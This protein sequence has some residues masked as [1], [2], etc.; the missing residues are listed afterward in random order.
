MRPRSGS[1]KRKL[2]DVISYANVVS[3]PAPANSVFSSEKIE[4]LT[5]NIATVTSLS[6]K[7][8]T[9]L[10]STPESD[11]KMVLMDMSKAIRLLNENQ[12]EI[13][14]AQTATGKNA[15]SGTGTGMVSLGVVPKRNRVLSQ[16]AAFEMSHAPVPRQ[17]DTIEA[18]PQFRSARKSPNSGKPSP[19]LRT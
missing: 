17:P 13:V 1:V 6:E 16:A 18:P 14:K 8:D 3:N 4:L 7:M 12:S 19:R 10:E 11:L 5:T 15:S 2:D 9:A